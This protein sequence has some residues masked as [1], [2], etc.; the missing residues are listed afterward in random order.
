MTI[1]RRIGYFLNTKLLVSQRALSF[2]KISASLLLPPTL[3]LAELYYI[4]T[5]PSVSGKMY[6]QFKNAEQYSA[7]DMTY[8]K[9][10]VAIID[11]LGNQRTEIS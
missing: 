8:I 2:K 9:R 7:L 5:E 4:C 1:F 11:P 3:A 6:V 10:L